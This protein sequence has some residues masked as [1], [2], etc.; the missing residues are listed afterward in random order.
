MPRSPEAVTVDA[1]NYTAW[2]GREE[3]RSTGH[4]YGNELADCH[5]EGKWD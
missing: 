4:R 3:E 5:Q 1:E 2:I